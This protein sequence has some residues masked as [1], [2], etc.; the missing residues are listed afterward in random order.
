[1]V[2]APGFYLLFNVENGKVKRAF[3]KPQLSELQ[4]TLAERTYDESGNYSVNGLNVNIREHLKTATNNGLY[5]GG[6]VSELVYGVEPGKAYVEGYETELKAT[7]YL[8]V[9]KATDEGRHEE[10]LISTSF[11]NYVYVKSVQG[12]W[13][14][15]SNNLSVN[16]KK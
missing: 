7:E 13:S 9:S 1:M 10:K 6:S 3:N 15:T 5:S 11:G 14:I 4:K 2:P 12:D 8:T 16:L